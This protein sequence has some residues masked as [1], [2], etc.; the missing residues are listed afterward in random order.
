MDLSNS[1]LY[2]K[3]KI[4]TRH[5]ER[6]REKQ[7]EKQRE[8]ERETERETERQTDK[9]AGRHTDR[10]Q[11]SDK[12]RQDTGICE[13]RSNGKQER[14]RNVEREDEQIQHWNKEAEGG[15]I[16]SHVPPDRD[17][18]GQRDMDP[19]VPIPPACWL[20][21][22]VRFPDDDGVLQKLLPMRGGPVTC[23]VQN[24]HS[25]LQFEMGSMRSEKPTCAPP[26][27]SEVSPPL[28]LK[29]FQCLTRRWPSLALSVKLG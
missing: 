20:P 3:H 8:G 5:R 15:I 27:L 28:P 22:V 2:Y 21:D 9:Q 23:S 18:T 14:N 24:I 17:G 12:Q 16:N 11:T 4:N 1:Q 13:H 6:E 10:T 19:V 7:T 25:S 26:R 29:W